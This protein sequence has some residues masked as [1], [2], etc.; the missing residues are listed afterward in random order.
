MWIGKSAGMRDVIACGLCRSMLVAVL[1]AV[2]FLIV[3]I[4]L[5]NRM[6]AL[7]AGF[8][9]LMSSHFVSWAEGG[10]QQS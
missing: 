3:E 1:C 9:P 5:R 6:A 2:T 7:I 10:T 4:Y 8:F